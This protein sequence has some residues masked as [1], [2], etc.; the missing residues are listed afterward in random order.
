MCTRQ[1]NFLNRQPCG[2]SS[3]QSKYLIRLEAGDSKTFKKIKNYNKHSSPIKR[4][5]RLEIICKR[6]TL[7]CANLS[8]VDWAIKKEKS[9]V[10]IKHLNK[11]INVDP[12][13]KNRP[14]IKRLLFL[15][16]LKLY[17]HSTRAA[18]LNT[19]RHQWNTRNA[20]YQLLL[21]IESS[22]DAYLSP[23]LVLNDITKVIWGT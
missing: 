3:G 6:A 23:F 4:K 22:S 21:S 19:Y 1:Q 18:P 17:A 16:C 8:Q 15:S 5:Q 9:Q 14:T 2:A 13:T 10:F 12:H 7:A 20:R 11:T